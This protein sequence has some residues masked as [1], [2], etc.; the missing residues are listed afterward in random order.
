MNTHD[1]LS[2]KSD[3]DADI[4][5][6]YAPSPTTL[7]IYGSCYMATKDAAK[8]LKILDPIGAVVATYDY[9]QNQWIEAASRRE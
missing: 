8:T 9:W 5:I 7:R 1:L 3:D 6:V 4:G 2:M